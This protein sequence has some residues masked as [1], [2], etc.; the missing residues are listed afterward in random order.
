MWFDL[1]THN[2]L[3][4]NDVATIYNAACSAIEA[5][6]EISSLQLCSASLHPWF[7]TPQNLSEQLNWLASTI[8]QPNVVAIGEVGLDKLRGADF[9]F[10]QQAFKEIAQLAES[11]QLPLIL[12]QVK[13]VNELIALHRALRPTTPWI[14]HGFRGK[15]ELALSAL[16]QG[17]F[18]SYGVHYHADALQA[19]PIDRLF[20][21]TDTASVAIE[22]LYKEA[23]KL[24]NCSIEELRE[25]VM[26]NAYSIFKDRFLLPH[27]IPF[28]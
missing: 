3:H 2:P 27:Y 12:H 24:R 20:L 22:A 5:V 28:Q 19:T 18:L 17:F 26:Q 16:K 21:E 23:A 7:I 15:R 1:H 4:R 11:V 25:G 9:L 6:E 13:A 14:L 10:Q 8:K